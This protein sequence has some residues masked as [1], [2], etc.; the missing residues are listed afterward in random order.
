MNY[1]KLH[2]LL[3]LCSERGLSTRPTEAASFITN[4]DASWRLLQQFPVKLL[5]LIDYPKVGRGSCKKVARRLPSADCNPV[6]A[7]PTERN[8]L[9][10]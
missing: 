3:H 7:R 8:N 6:D 1:E 9:P 5:W 2:W 4:Y 10:L